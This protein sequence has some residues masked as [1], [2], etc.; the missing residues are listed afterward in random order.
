[1]NNNQPVFRHVLGS[2]QSELQGLVEQI[3]SGIGRVLER[4]GLVKRDM[5]NAWLSSV[6]EPGPLDDLIG[7]SI[8]YRIA[9]GPRAGRKLFTLQ[10]VPPRLRPRPW[11]PAMWR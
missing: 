3:A 11:R 8:T 2:G 6:A 7:H 1:M 9:V 10:P 4:R 5:E